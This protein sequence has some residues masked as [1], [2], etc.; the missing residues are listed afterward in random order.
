MTEKEN[1]SQ[2]QIESIVN[3]IVDAVEQRDLSP[4]RAVI[5]EK[6]QLR[7]CLEQTNG[8]LERKIIDSV[9]KGVNAVNRQLDIAQTSLENKSE[10]LA[11]NNWLWRE[12]NRN[13]T[14]T[15]EAEVFFKMGD[16]T[17]VIQFKTVE[18]DKQNF[19]FRTFEL[20]EI[21]API[22]RH[23]SVKGFAKFK[24]ATQ[25][26][27][28]TAELL[29]AG[30]LDELIAHYQ[31]VSVEF[32]EDESVIKLVTQ[33]DIQALTDTETAI[34]RAFPPELIQWW[35]NESISQVRSYDWGYAISIYTPSEMQEMMN[36]QGLT[37]SVKKM[38]MAEVLDYFHSGEFKALLSPENYQALNDK[39]T[40]VG[41]YSLSDTDALYIY[42]DE[43]DQFG[44]V[45][46]NHE[47]RHFSG[48]DWNA[49]Y[50]MLLSTSRATHKLTN[51]VAQFFELSAYQLWEDA[52]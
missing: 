19:L 24:A 4:L 48:L 29:K 40:I 16:R 7:E 44:V 18:V 3:Q 11:P 47:W 43:S 6:S 45:E 20:T 22:E 33:P 49:E 14:V 50:R 1:M 10:K 26:P 27:D 13:M 23:L 41:S 38:G 35:Q 34:G 28:N 36:D 8:E 32:D 39:F 46:Y 17:L 2:T 25:W 9:N 5:V 12:L 42:C 15:N 31:K 51:L 37:H 52:E 30:Q 21:Q